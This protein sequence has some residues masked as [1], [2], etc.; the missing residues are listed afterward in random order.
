LTEDD[1]VLERWPW[2]SERRERWRARQQVREAF[3][4]RIA[5][6]DSEEV[7]F[8]AAL[9]AETSGWIRRGRR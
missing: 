9:R 1:V 2:R 5:E 8:W 6:I 7:E 4:K 3:Q